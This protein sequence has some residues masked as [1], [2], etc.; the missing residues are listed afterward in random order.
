MNTIGKTSS[1]TDRTPTKSS[2]TS[3]S[4]PGDGA[5]STR[6]HF[7]TGTSTIG[8][9]PGSAGYTA[10]AAGNTIK[11]PAPGGGEQ[12]LV[13]DELNQLSEVTR[14]GGTVAKMVYDAAGGRLL[15]QQGDTTT[16]YV[17]GSEISLNRV[18]GAVSAN[19]YYS[20]GGQTVAVRTGPSN[21][22]VTTLVSDWQGTTHHQVTNS[23]GALTTT[24]QDPYGSP[25]GTPPSGWAGER[26]FVGG[27]KDA[28]G[29]TRVGAR[30]YDPIVQR[31]VTV[32][33]LQDLADPLQWNPYLYAN[34][35]PISKSDPTGLKP[36]TDFFNCGYY[37]PP[38][39][40]KKAEKEWKKQ[41]KQ[42]AASKNAPGSAPR[43]PG[44]SATRSS[45]P[46]RYASCV[47][48]PKSIVS[49]QMPQ[50]A[51]SSLGTVQVSPFDRWCDEPG[52]CAP[53]KRQPMSMGDL[54][55]LGSLLGISS[56]MGATMKAP[57]AVGSKA[58]PVAGKS[59]TKSAP[60]ALPVGPWGQRVVDARGK[61]PSSWEPGV[62]N[63][64]AVGTKWFDP[65]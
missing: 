59:A 11:R 46:C 37:I 16:L 10:D 41:S 62:P 1:R 27:T 22:S 2:T 43:R 38:H 3:Y 5:S 28:T 8:D 54:F 33:P 19:R 23:T 60:R 6:P 30:D 64:K 45:N 18:T 4:Y 47:A 12:E 26:G 24:W 34:N 35:T 58:A 21:D 57:L 51:S 14:N 65:A 20:H 17:A 63:S 56:W 50:Y 40:T 32:D 31:F 55:F 61:L 49:L 29:L 25:R 48:P 7:V 53:D 44:G 13:W 42:V 9:A 39:V 15:R 36:C 52:V